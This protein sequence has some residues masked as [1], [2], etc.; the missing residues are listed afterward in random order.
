[1]ACGRAQTIGAA[2]RRPRRNHAQ[3]TLLAPPPTYVTKSQLGNSSQTFR[4][5]LADLVDQ[6]QHYGDATGTSSGAGHEFR[7]GM[8][9]TE[10]ERELSLSLRTGVIGF[11]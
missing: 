2:E 4:A 11:H 8:E 10:R 6:A 7:E 5:R 9:S 1:M 3:R